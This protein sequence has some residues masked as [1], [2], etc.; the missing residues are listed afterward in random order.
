MV[1]GNGAHPTEGALGN[2]PFSAGAMGTRRRQ[3]S[4]IFQANRPTYAWRNRQTALGP[5]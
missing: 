2:R 4:L 1:I 3:G 5:V